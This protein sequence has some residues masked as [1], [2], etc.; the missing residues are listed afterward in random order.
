MCA[1][2]WSSFTMFGSQVREFGIKLTQLNIQKPS[3]LFSR[4][5]L[6]YQGLL[7]F[8]FLLN[9]DLMSHFSRLPLS[10][11][12]ELVKWQCDLVVVEGMGRAIH[13]NLLTTFTCD[14]LK[15]AVIKNRWLAQRQVLIYQL[16]IEFCCDNLSELSLIRSLIQMSAP[17]MHTCMY[18]Q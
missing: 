1:R 9:M 14:S 3:K 15:L 7:N 17:L 4:Y 12:D 11:V 16:F 10:L 8:Q 2:V 18:I 6:I 5:K 13:T